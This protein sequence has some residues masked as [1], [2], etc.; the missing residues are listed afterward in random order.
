LS[1]AVTSLNPEAIAL[2]NGN[3]VSTGTAIS[4][5]PSAEGYLVAREGMIDYP[6]PGRVKLGELTK[7]EEKI[8][9]ETDLKRYLKEPI[10]RIRYLIYKIMEVTVKSRP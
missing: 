3:T 2:F 6:V 1:I 7:S 5:T 8:R 9:L 4:S 10:V